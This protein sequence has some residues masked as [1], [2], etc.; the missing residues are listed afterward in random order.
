MS[1]H[2]NRKYS[3][4]RKNSSGNIVIK[5]AH[6]LLKK[7]LLI[8]DYN[9]FC[10]KKKRKGQTKQVTVSLLM[11]FHAIISIKDSGEEN[12]NRLIKYTEH[13]HT[14]DKQEKRNKSK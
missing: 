2:R 13:T 10:Q 12:D 9:S 5:W 7:N 11:P 4:I 8:S 14:P 3:W 1:I 6:N